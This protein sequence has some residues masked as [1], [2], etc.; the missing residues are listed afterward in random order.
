MNFLKKFIG[1]TPI[2]EVASIPSGK[3]FLT[4]AP[5]SPKGALECL[6][7]DALIKIK[8]TTKEHYYQISVIRAYQEGEL[9]LESADDEDD[10]GESDDSNEDSGNNDEK[11]FSIDPELKF[12]SYTRSDGVQAISWKDLNGDLGDRF[13]FVVDEDIKYTE[14][15]NFTFS[16]YKCLYEHRY[17]KSA[18]DITDISQLS[19]FVY[20]PNTDDEA[21]EMDKFS[22]FAMSCASSQDLR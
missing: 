16:L 2:D 14:V 7:N 5:F 20:D 18:D 12:R 6:Y 21:A 17:Q 9:N 1:A 4:R 11:V 10:G 22:R 3:L 19:E 13:E 8:K 15:D